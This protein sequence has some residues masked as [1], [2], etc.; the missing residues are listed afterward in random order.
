MTGAAAG[1]TTGADGS[2]T[3]A[4]TMDVGTTG[5]MISKKSSGPSGQR[6]QKAPRYS[7]PVHI[8]RG[9]TVLDYNISGPGQ[10]FDT[11]SSHCTTPPAWG[12]APGAVLRK[13]ERGTLEA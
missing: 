5:A 10:R 8:V 7:D 9:N 3:A 12:Q 11:L 1:I 4:G 2:M 6:A 13:G